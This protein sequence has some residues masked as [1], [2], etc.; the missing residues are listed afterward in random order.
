MDGGKYSTEDVFGCTDTNFCT[1]NT[2]N[3]DNKIG[4][5]SLWSLL[6]SV[7][8]LAS[9][10]TIKATPKGLLKY[11]KLHLSDNKRISFRPTRVAKYR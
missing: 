2:S 3:A 6:S 1:E 8:R 11:H 10:G 5:V 4:K 9:F 7:F